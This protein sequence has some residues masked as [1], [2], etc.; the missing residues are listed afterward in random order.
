M[1]IINNEAINKDISASATA[2]TNIKIIT[3]QTKRALPVARVMPNET[4]MLLLAN[5]FIADSKRIISSGLAL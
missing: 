4:K 2:P 3:R 5:F 1:Q